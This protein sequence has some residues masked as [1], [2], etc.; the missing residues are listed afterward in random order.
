MRIAFVHTP[1]PQRTVKHRK[2]YWAAFDARYIA[3]HPNVRPMRKM[4][5]ELP[6]WIPWLAGVLESAGFKDLDAIDL[7]GDC[8]VI[9]G[10][11]ESRIAHRLESRPAD[12]YLFSPMA[13]NLP[14][15]LRIAEMAKTANPA[16]TTIFGGVVATPL[17]E[18]VAR[19]PAVDYVVRDRG[20]RAL[21]ALLTA[22]RDR[23]CDIA[24]VGNLSFVGADG[25]FCTSGRLFPRI[26]PSEL[27]FPKVDIFPSDTG[28][29]LRYI[30]Q[31]FAL[32]CPF[33]CDFCTIQTIGRRPDYFPPARVLAEITAYRRHFGEH[34][35]I[36]FG[37]ETFTLNFDRTVEICD[38]LAAA[39]DV[40]F[41]CQT[42]LNCMADK[43]FPRLLHQGGCRWLEVGLESTN[44]ASQHAFKQHTSLAPL[45]GTLEALRDAGIPVCS[46][47][48]VGLPGESISDMH[49]T[50]DAAC[51]L[52]SRDLLYASYL[53]V[54]VPY[55]GSPLFADP[56]RYGMRLQHRQLDLY[57][58]ELPPVFDTPLA[59]SDEV[60]ELFI[61]GVEML[62]AQM[63]RA[64][65]LG[66]GDA[67]TD[68]A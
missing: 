12:V 47:I 6:H 16:C 4:L 39:G 45:E 43:R 51:D 26:A 59:S 62:T 65:W 63:R 41:D 68:A 53:S 57:N 29:D 58:E 20:E 5:Y 9:D 48:I 7:Y 50:L 24:E 33:T 54:C 64:S 31:N 8:A 15:A 34:H 10:I 37:D 27:A 30:R 23:R 61:Q 2:A 32:G 35:H 36:Y 3:A 66:P 46:Y 28:Q 11:D 40:T 22:L 44:S 14:H 19:H 25:E 56:E 1:V 17:H 60:Y 18:A 55:P 38:A 21:P 13:L 49:R 67:P 52:M 42:R